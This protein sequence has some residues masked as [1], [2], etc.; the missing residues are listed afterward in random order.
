VERERERERER[1]REKDLVY[2]WQ[3]ERAKS[4][5]VVVGS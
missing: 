5:D 3:R 4:A 1:M 2:G